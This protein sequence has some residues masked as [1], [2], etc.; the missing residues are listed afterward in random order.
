MCIII[1]PIMI[2]FVPKLQIRDLD[3]LFIFQRNRS[4]M[5]RFCTLA[6]CFVWISEKINLILCR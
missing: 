5:Y 3:I 6:S 1:I 2:Y 4:L